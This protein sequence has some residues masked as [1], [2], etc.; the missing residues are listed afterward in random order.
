MSMLQHPAD[1]KI[2]NYQFSFKARLGKGAYGTVYAGK[3]IN[4]NSVVALKV[5]DKKLLQTDYAN[6]LIAS[7]IEIMKKL[8]DQH[9]VKLIDVLQ[10]VNNTYIVTEYCNGGDLREYLKKK[11][12]LSEMEALQIFKDLLKGIK[13]LLKIGIIHRDIKP[14]NIM[15]HEGVF[16]LTDFGFAKQVS[17][18]IEAIMNSLVGTPL[19]MSPQILKRQKYTPK[20]DIWSMGLILYEMIYGTTPWHSQ[21]LVELISKLD[22]KPLS[23]PPTVKATE[24]TKNLIKQCLQLSEEKRISW[25][26]LFQQFELQEKPLYSIQTQRVK[27]RTESMC[28][29]QLVN[30]HNRSLSN[31]GLQRDE[32]SPQE[33]NQ[34]KTY[35]TYLESQLPRF[36]TDVEQERERSNS[37]MNKFNT[38]KLETFL[39][40]VHTPPLP[41]K[42]YNSTSNKSANDSFRTPSAMQSNSTNA[43]NRQHYEQEVKEFNTD[44]DDTNREL[45]T[46]RTKRASSLSSNTL[47]P[48][49]MNSKKAHIV[50]L[51]KIIINQQDLIPNHIKVKELINKMIQGHK[52]LLQSNSDL[53]YTI[54]DG[55]EVKSIINQMIDYLNANQGD[56]FTVQLQVMLLLL[57]NYNKLIGSNVKTGQ[58]SVSNSLQELIK[59]NQQIQQNQLHLDPKGLRDTINSQLQ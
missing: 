54:S 19:Y 8:D 36:R 28:Q 32:K 10:S 27:Q 59:K 48:L 1:K 7:E 13:S 18:G 23:F 49:M 55:K 31:T 34:K 46:S 12:S 24:S 33:N 51:L 5:I 35:K 25:E 22:S 30:K 39:D 45:R 42:K 16:K 9:V 50:Q 29:Y 26:Q 58:L 56:H 43:S 6:Q 44:K 47:S 17:G 21:N 53:I 57:I 3:N 37:Q 38:Q 11:K 41:N 2:Q 52:L 4:D 15:I 40:T 14:A 20:C